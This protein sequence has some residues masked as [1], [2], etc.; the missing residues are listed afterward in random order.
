MQ[1]NLA[2]AGSGRLYARKRVMRAVVACATGDSPRAV[3]APRRRLS[4]CRLARRERRRLSP[5][6][7]AEARSARRCVDMTRLRRC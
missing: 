1:K 4:C 5:D 3:A 6:G 7:I 2:K